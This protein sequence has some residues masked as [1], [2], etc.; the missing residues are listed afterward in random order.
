[1][2]GGVRGRWNRKAEEGESL[3]G[4]RRGAGQGRRGR[5]V[6]GQ[7][8]KG[9]GEDWQVGTRR[10]R[11]ALHTHAALVCSGLLC[12]VFCSAC[13]VPT[14]SLPHARTGEGKPCILIQNHEKRTQLNLFCK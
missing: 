12:S 13:H 5:R 7:A 6:E 10:P 1:M 4:G 11:Q 9:E 8:R 14:R 2:G 3:T